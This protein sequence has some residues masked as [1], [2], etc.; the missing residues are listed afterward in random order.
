MRHESIPTVTPVTTA[1]AEAVIMDA[2]LA[3]PHSFDIQGTDQDLAHK[4]N[5]QGSVDTLTLRGLGFGED[6]TFLNAQREPSSTPPRPSG[7][8]RMDPG[9][10]CRIAGQPP[11]PNVRPYKT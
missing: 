5:K 8:N 10:R 1:E 7:F 11:Q 9:E 6:L 4:L 2:G 3:V